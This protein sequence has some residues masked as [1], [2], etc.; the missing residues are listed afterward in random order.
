MGLYTILRN[1]QLEVQLASDY[2]DNGWYFSNGVAFHEDCNEGSIRN[3][4]FQPEVD[5]EYTIK[6]RVAGLD[7]GSLDVYLGGTLFGTITSPGYYELSSITEDES[8]LLFTTGFTNLQI[9]SYQINE[10]LSEGQ[11]IVYDSYSRMYIGHSSVHGDR[12]E[13]FLDDL[14]VFKNGQPWIQDRNESR[15]TFFGNKYPSII[16]FY[17]NVE[18][19]QDKDFYFITLNSTSPWRVDI[20]APPRE[21]KRNGQR[22]RIKPGNFKFDKGRYVADILR[23]MNDPR[24]DNELQALMRGAMIQGQYIEVTLTNNE[25]IEV[26]LESVEIDVSLK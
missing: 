5:K 3:I 9:L 1:S 22:S 13:G 7:S 6:L 18:Y 26:Q 12:M 8:S 24:F 25:D 15:N 11:T 21:G 16:R 4:V 20:T 19:N 10:G 23:D 14:I 2:Q 17:C